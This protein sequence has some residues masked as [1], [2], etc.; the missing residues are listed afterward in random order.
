[1][2]LLISVLAP[3]MAS[4]EFPQ[5]S[6]Y[7]WSCSADTAVVMYT[8][9]DIL[10]VSPFQMCLLWLR[11]FP[12]WTKVSWLTGSHLG[13]HEWPH[14]VLYTLCCLDWTTA[15]LLV[16]LSTNLQPFGAEDGALTN[17]PHGQDPDRHLLNL[18]F[19][20]YKRGFSLEWTMSFIAEI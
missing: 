11:W 17:E 2:G 12:S 6:T 10:G 15:I 16:L 18:D 3:Q 20:L 8:C 13:W 14:F 9:A 7:V 19:L 5:E 1:M 4:R